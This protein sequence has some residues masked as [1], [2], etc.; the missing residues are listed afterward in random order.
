M[1]TTK[2]GGFSAR[3]SEAEAGFLQ[4]PPGPAPA[5]TH[6]HQPLTDDSH[7]LSLPPVTPGDS[8]SAPP[9]REGLANLRDSGGESEGTIKWTALK[10]D[11]WHGA[12]V[13]VHQR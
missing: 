1:L 8:V 4:G 7:C 3:T 11:P 9:C 13:Q 12:R 2:M 5:L 10:P 6:P